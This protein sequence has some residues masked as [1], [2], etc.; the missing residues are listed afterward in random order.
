MYCV[1]LFLFQFVKAIGVISKS[2]G[3]YLQLAIQQINNCAA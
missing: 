1:L 2:A 3:P